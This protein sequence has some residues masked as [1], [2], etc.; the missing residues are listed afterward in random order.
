MMNPIA[1]L[2][3][4]L[5]LAVLGSAI[6]LAQSVATAELHVTVKDP[7]GGVVTKATVIVRDEARN[8]QRMVKDSDDGEYQLLLLPPGLYTVTVDAP[9]FARL[10]AKDVK[11]TVGQ[12]AELPV[13]LKLAG[14]TAEV[15][16]SGA[17]EMVETQRTSS[18]TTIEQT[19]IDNLPINGRNYINFALTN[20]QL[21]RDTAP[22]IGAAPTSGLNFGGQRA[23]SNLVNVDGMDAVDNSV[24]GIR[25]TVSQEAV[26][27]FQIIT[28]G[29]AAEY[30]RASGG[31][32]N[33]ITR[34]GSNEFHGTAFAYL[35]HRDIQADNPFSTVPN[36]AYTR[37]QSGVTLS[38]PIN[39]DKTFWFFSYETTRR[40][41]TGFS[42]IG[43]NNFGLVPFNSGTIGLPFGTVLLTQPQVDF[44]SANPANP[45]TP[46]YVALAGRSSGAALDGAWPAALGGAPAFATTAAPLPGA[47]VALNSL[48]GNY[49]IS[50]GTSLIGVRLDHR[51]NNSHGGMLRVNVSP[52]TVTGIQVN[53]QNQNFGQNA[54]SRTS[55][56]TYRDVNAT[57]QHVWTIGNDKI[58]ELRYQYARRGLLYTFS[59][60]DDTAGDSNTLP[61]GGQVAINIPGDAF[62][63]REPFSFVDRVEQRHQF[64][65]N[66]SWQAGKHNIKLGGDFN[67]IPLE[68][69]F[70]VNFGAL[71]NFGVLPAASID[72][73]GPGPGS[74]AGFPSFSPVQAYGLGIPQSFVQGI[75][76]P[77]DSFKNKILGFFIQDSWRL[78]SNLTLN[79]GVRYDVEFTPE[80]PAINA[81]SQAAEVAL[82]IT[83]GIPRDTNN[84]APRVGLA[85]DPFNDGKTVVRASYGIF[86]DHPL[87]ALAFDSDVADGSQAPQLI[88]FGG[89]PCTA[90]S[91]AS[92]LNLNAT[93]VFQGLVN[94]ANC[95]GPFATGMGYLPG[96]QR[97]DAFL[98]NSIFVNQNYLNAFGPGAHFPL[99]LQPFGFPTAQN[100]EYAYSHQANLT[101]ERDLGRDFALSLS[102]NFNGG[103]HLNRPINVNPVDSEALVVNWERAVA[104]GAAAPTS[105]PLTG[106]GAAN[107]C[108]VGPLG[109]FILPAVVSFFRPSGVNP[110]L[111]P[112]F[113]ACGPIITAVSA[114][115]GLGLGV[116]V[117]FSDMVANFGN[118]SSVYHG[119]T[120]NLRKRFSNHYEF[121]ASYTW[122]HAIDD[123]TDLQSLLSPLDSRRPDLERANSAFDQRHRF[124]FSAVYQSGRLSGEGFWSKFFSDWTVA[125]IIEVSSGRPFAILTGSDRNFDFGPNTDRPLAVASGTVNICGDSAVASVFSPAGAFIPAC[126]VDGVFDGVASAPLVG[127]VPRNAGIRPTTVFT[128]LRIAR[129]LHLTERV[130]LDLI[131]D[132]FNIV[133]RFNVADVN[134]LFT[135]AGTPT[136]AFD[137]RQFQFALKLSW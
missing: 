64:T 103:R 133:N 43:A 3:S 38:G 47:F 87:L 74:F 13:E 37:V 61:D 92:P 129:R 77:H 94:D 32:V 20:S 130:G 125:P 42:T 80:F 44:V 46:A 15:T 99:I 90:A 28:N 96:E 2:F 33:I 8:F 22:S 76:N 72:P 116:E 110:S 65:D 86:Y 56:Q 35:R 89:A 12:R 7:N 121:L 19:R 81:L 108:G 82:G 101:I 100:F 60:I 27:E 25:S 78:A 106:I 71:H 5:W 132:M 24:N 97:F 88:L 131:A 23:R 6:A 107:P 31:V 115:F 62:F 16:V 48:R 14:A 4:L 127:N 105:N 58:N 21:A 40:Q 126:F 30:G 102:Y 69:D 104:A 137:P 63:G 85:W 124:V 120:A 134:V 117:P 53:A 67:Y 73:D 54:F 83:Q 118:G 50:E 55:V 59:Q 112:L 11:V 122:S 36:P 119:L 52:S 39:K 75:G 26:Q 93:N 34:S 66:F 123:S 113:A 128:D 29:Y 111:A 45:N 109:P 51:F 79:Y 1:R 10:I 68:A 9:G 18:T 17:A 70:T 91:S 57:A 98:A 136:S 49:P 95:V 135:Q 41:E 84:I 114:E